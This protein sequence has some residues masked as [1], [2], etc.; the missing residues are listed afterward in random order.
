MPLNLLK[1]YPEL[2]TLLGAPEENKRSLR[3]IF[4]RDIA[5][6]TN[7]CFRGIRIHPIKAEGVD[8]MDTLFTHLTCKSEEVEVTGGVPY[9]RRIFDRLR[10]ERL[11][12]IGHHINECSPQSIQ[13]FT[14]Q[15]RDQKKRVDVT[16]TYIYD[17]AQEYVIILE[18]QR[19]SGYYLLTAFHITEPSVQK[20]LKKKMR[21]AQKM[22]AST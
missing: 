21:K 14:L 8:N 13:V 7:F 2:L 19:Q 6:Q 9:K 15:E 22:A 18:H 11:H 4:N 3:G 17:Q 1:K 5:E 12:W 16:K 20:Q 10:S